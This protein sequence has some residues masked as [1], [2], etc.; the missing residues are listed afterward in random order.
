MFSVL[1][2]SRQGSCMP[3]LA[4]YDNRHSMCSLLSGAI[5]AFQDVPAKRHEVGA[6]HAGTLWHDGCVPVASGSREV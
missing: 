1:V 4:L 6:V 5:Q 2:A 3:A